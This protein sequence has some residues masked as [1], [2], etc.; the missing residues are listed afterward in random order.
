MAVA[1]P[2]ITQPFAELH[3]LESSMED[4]SAAYLRALNA[5]DTAE[6]TQALGCAPVY[7]R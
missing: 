1:A 7:V 2:L 5:A 6:E 3:A 4:P